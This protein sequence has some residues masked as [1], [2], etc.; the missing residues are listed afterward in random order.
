[1]ADN[2]TFGCEERALHPSGLISL[3][4]CAWK[5]LNIHM[6]DYEGDS[7]PTADTGSAVHEAARLFHR[8]A[9]V[10]EALRGMGAN[11]MR[12]KL[13]NLAE[14]TQMFVS[15]AADE[16][17]RTAKVLLVEHPV[18]FTI[19]PL[20]DD[21]TGAPIHVVGTLDQVREVNGVARLLDIKTSKRDPLEV[22]YGATFQIAA[23]CA[24]ASVLLNRRVEPGPLILPRRYGAD[25]SRS[26][27]FYHYPWTYD[28]VEHIL[29][30]VRVA[31]ANIRAGRVHHVPNSEC[32]WCPLRSPDLC[33]PQ[34]K[35]WRAQ[36]AAS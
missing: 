8:G 7:G 5:A 19:A 2:T 24:G 31:V 4:Q 23:Y 12:Y 9:S 22:M 15:Y 29:Y 18:K 26:P 13:A 32:K 20:P 14:A 10:S 35:K 25:P 3:S 28:D 6:N 11:I 33:Y 27:V 36:R 1:M 16:R 21:P 17:N 34:L 30:G